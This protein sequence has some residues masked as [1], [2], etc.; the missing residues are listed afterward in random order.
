MPK[1]HILYIF[2]EYSHAFAVDVA[3][4][5]YWIKA[6]TLP[7]VHQAGLVQASGT[8]AL[9]DTEDE[10]VAEPTAALIAPSVTAAHGSEMLSKLGT[11]PGK[12]PSRAAIEVTQIWAEL[13]EPEDISQAC[14]RTCRRCSWRMNKTLVEEG[15]PF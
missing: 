15:R 7:V 11:V 9:R 8:G 3:I 13:E 6:E 4:P 10:R 2:R 14:S 1:L 5:R 12:P